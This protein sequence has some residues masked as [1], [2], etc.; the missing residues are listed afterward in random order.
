MMMKND[1][2]RKDDLTMKARLLAIQT[3]VS[4]SSG[5]PWAR[6]TFRTRT[7]AGQSVV[8][9][10]FVKPELVVGLEEDTDVYVSVEL[11]DWQRAAV[12]RISPVG[13]G[14]GA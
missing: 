4:K 3:G 1:E 10:H 13:K 9:D 5:K 7:A 12:S 11:D 8:K 2:G 14:A 6:V